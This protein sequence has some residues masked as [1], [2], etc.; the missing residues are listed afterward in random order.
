MSWPAHPL[1]C[2]LL[3]GFDAGLVEGVDAVEGS[4]DGG[5][6]FERLLQVAEVLFVWLAESYGAVGASGFGEGPPG[7]VALDV[8]ELC[9]GVS[10]EVSDAFE[11]LVGSWNL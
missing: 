3:S 5:L 6:H 4:G 11:V 2:D 9:H 10:P 1:V 8:Q 7:G